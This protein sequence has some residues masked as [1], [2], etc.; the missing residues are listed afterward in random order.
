MAGGKSTSFYD[1]NGACA[2]HFTWLGKA[3]FV[4]IDV[5]C[6]DPDCAGIVCRPAANGC[7]TAESCS[8]GS[9]P[10]DLFAAAGTVCRESAGAWG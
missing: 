9:C 3:D 6:E 10:A 5:D 4:F 1:M 7:D 8:N 2:E